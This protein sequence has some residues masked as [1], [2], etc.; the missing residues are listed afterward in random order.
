MSAGL[1]CPEAKRSPKKKAEEKK[2]GFGL[3][4]LTKSTTAG[5]TNS[6]AASAVPRVGSDRLAKGG[7]NRTW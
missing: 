3:S 7:D 5:K 1:W 4:N 2:K 6:R